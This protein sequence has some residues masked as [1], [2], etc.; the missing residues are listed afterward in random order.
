[1]GS[2]DLNRNPKVVLNPDILQKQI[3]GVFDS[4]GK[5][6]LNQNFKNLI[7]IYNYRNEYMIMDEDLELKSRL[8]TIDTI[9][10]ARFNVVKI[11]DG[12]HKMNVPSLKTI[13]ILQLIKTPFCGIKAY[14]Q[15]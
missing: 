5:L 11:P 14:W 6:L 8:K 7:Y 2:L 9:S 1:L 10:R 12:R 15:V 13:K 3:D 4:D